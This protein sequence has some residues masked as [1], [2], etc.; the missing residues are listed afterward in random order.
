MAYLHED[1]NEFKIAVNL[2]SERFHVLPVAVEKDY[3]VT[4]ILRELSDRL[5]FLVFKGGTSLSKCHKVI[6]RFSEDI[7]ITIDTKLTQGQMKKLK[8]A[9]KETAEVLG[10]TIPNLNETRSRR[11]Y[12]RY[13]LSYKS[14][15]SE[16]DEIIQSMVI[17]ETSFAE[18]SFPTEILP[19]HSYI[20]E[21]MAEEAP[22]DLVNFRLDPFQMKVQSLDRTLVDKVFAV[23]DYYLGDNVKKHSRH[24]YDIYKLLPLVPQ[25]EN[26]RELVR[27]VRTVRAK[28]KICLSAQPEIDVPL[29]LKKIVENDVYKNDYETVTIRI[30][31]EQIPYDTAVNALSIIADTGMF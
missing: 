24:I 18:V 5:G 7:D 30:L 15:A 4:M 19:V 27:E 6:Q 20:G 13:E 12:N 1:K 22:E 14:A 8:E 3:Y 17:L 16:L 21:M 25:N 10:L 2:A 31:E 9:I 29:I 26:F 28:N 23:C 11:S